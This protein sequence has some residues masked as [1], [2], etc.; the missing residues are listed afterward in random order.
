[1]RTQNLRTDN[2]VR[3]TKLQKFNLWVSHRLLLLLVS[4]FG[5]VHFPTLRPKHDYLSKPLLMMN[6][7]YQGCTRYQATRDIGNE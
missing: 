6:E 3:G 4:I 2:P 7:S 1:M 5:P